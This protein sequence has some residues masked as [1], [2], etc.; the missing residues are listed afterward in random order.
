MDKGAKT[1]T[2]PRGALIWINPV[3]HLILLDFDSCLIGFSTVPEGGCAAA[4]AP[5]TSLGHGGAAPG[6]EG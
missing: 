5:P 1:N 2:G 3:G 6:S 4:A